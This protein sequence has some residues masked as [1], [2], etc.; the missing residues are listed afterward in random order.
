MPAR[1]AAAGGRPRQRGDH[2]APRPPCTRSGPSVVQELLHPQLRFTGAEQ[3]LAEGSPASPGAASAGWRCSAQRALELPRRVSPP[4]WSRP[5]PRPLTSRR[6]SRPRRRHHRRRVGLA[7]RRGRPRRRPAGGL[8]CHRALHRPRAGHVHRPRAHPPR[9]RPR[10]RRR[11]QRPHL[12]R[13][14]AIRPAEPPAELDCLLAWADSVRQMGV[15]TNADT[16]RET[17]VAVRARRRGHRPVPHRAPVPRRPAAASI[18]SFLL[19][20]D[21]TSAPAGA[22]GADRR[23]ARGLHGAAAGDGDRPVTVGCSTRP[24]TSSSPTT[25]VRRPGARPPGRRAARGQPDAR[26]ARRPPGAAER[27]ALPRAGGGAVLCLGRRRPEGITP[28][29]R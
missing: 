5:R 26:P 16:A 7:R 6:S 13:R 19:A 12:C 14:L 11:P 15:R 29:S 25:A 3:Q 22:A 10:D 28:R 18:R 20:E 8:R 21:E 1:R 9:G 27:G 2:R 4:C 23:P 24:C 17:D